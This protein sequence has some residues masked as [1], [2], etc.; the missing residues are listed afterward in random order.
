MQL[1]IS[2]ILRNKFNRRQRFLV[3]GLLALLA[4]FIPMTMDAVN[5]A[6]A[7]SYEPID[8]AYQANGD[9]ITFAWARD[10]VANRLNNSA[11]TVEAWLNPS[12]CSNSVG[13]CNYIGKNPS[14]LY[15]I[16]N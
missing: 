13:Y 1:R 7:D 10:G 2:A 5:R 6:G 11:S 15:A 8:Y 3:G 12:T 14:F 16:N 9:S 4:I